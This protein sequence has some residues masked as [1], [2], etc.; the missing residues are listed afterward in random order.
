V[1]DY[2]VAHSHHYQ[3]SLSPGPPARPGI[4][5]PA[6]RAGHPQHDLRGEM[7][8]GRWAASATGT[9]TRRHKLGG[10][11]SRVTT[12]V[13]TSAAAHTRLRLSHALRRTATPS[14]L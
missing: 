12:L 8:R 4:G 6:T 7:K 2:S 5:R 9:R 10:Y 13:T 3:G 1:P 14:L 11:I